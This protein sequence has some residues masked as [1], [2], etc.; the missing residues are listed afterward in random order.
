MRKRAL[1]QID[2]VATE[3]AE[4]IDNLVDLRVERVR[5]DNRIAEVFPLSAESAGVGVRQVAGRRG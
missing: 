2:A 1:A 3:D 5:A 4:I